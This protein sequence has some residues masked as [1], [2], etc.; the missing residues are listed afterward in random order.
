MPL[1]ITT[2][3]PI[4]LHQSLSPFLH[5]I[6]PPP[7]GPH[8]T[9][10][11]NPSPLVPSLCSHQ[12]LA[13]WSP[14]FAHTKRQPPGLHTMLTPNPSPLVPS[15]CSHQTL[16]S[17]SPHHAHTKP[18]PTGPQSFF[19]H[20]LLYHFI[21]AVPGPQTNTSVNAGDLA[22]TL[23]NNTTKLVVAFPIID[24]HIALETD[25]IYNLSLMLFQPDPRVHL[26]PAHLTVTIKDN[27]GEVPLVI[28][29]ELISQ[30]VR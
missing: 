22:L 14:V 24:N 9:L 2:P 19:I 27:D 17:W 21:S 11:P 10:T 23:G 13:H 8:T 7:P 30:H 1:Q 4:P 28:K 29:T 20:E 25:V 5:L 18:Q 3:L 12:T 26:S 16:A 15:L 6:S